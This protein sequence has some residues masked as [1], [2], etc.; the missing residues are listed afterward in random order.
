MSINPNVVDT[1]MIKVEDEDG[2]VE[3]KEQGTYVLTPF[4]KFSNMV[5]KSPNLVNF[6]NVVFTRLQR[7]K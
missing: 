2:E 3:I 1:P 6:G 4:F 7:E 5:M